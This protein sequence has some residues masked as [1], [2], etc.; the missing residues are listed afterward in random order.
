MLTLQQERR[1]NKQIPW[2]ILSFHLLWL[3]AA[4]NIADLFSALQLFVPL[5]LG[6][7]RG[8]YSGSSSSV[9]FADSSL[10]SQC[11]N[12]EG[13]QGCPWT[14]FAFVFASSMMVFISAALTTLS[15]LTAA[16]SFVSARDL[17][18]VS[19]FTVGLF[20]PCVLLWI[21]YAQAPDRPFQISL[22]CRLF[23][24]SKW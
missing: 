15:P 24:L 23:P 13:L 9:S 1:Q 2:P 7:S 12:I 5:A 14:S 20:A 19:G 21:W 17:P 22:S 18:W 4:F 11:P 3:K 8:F 10:W 16:F 6:F